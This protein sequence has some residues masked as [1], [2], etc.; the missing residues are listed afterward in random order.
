MNVGDLKKYF[1][2]QSELKLILQ[3]KFNGL[4]LQGIEIFKDDS[5]SIFVHILDKSCFN[6]SKSIRDSVIV[7]ISYYFE[8]CD[9]FEEPPKQNEQ[10][11][12]LL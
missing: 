11:K 5:D 10:V 3:K 12:L 9:I 7:L 1:H 4:Y 6:K 8:Y 2:R